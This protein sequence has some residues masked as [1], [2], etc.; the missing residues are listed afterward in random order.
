MAG[1]EESR[2]YARGD[3]EDLGIS[4]RSSEIV[5]AVQRIERRIKRACDVF[6]SSSVTAF[7]R[8]TARVFFQQVGCIQQDQPRQ[9]A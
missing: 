1:V 3:F 9:F 4:R 5:E 2:T 8:A 7:A 6:M